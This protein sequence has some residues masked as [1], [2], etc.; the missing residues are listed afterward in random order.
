MERNMD[1]VRTILRVAAQGRLTGNGRGLSNAIPAYSLAE[2]HYHVQIMQEAGLVFQK[3]RSLEM[4]AL[5]LTG[6]G[7]EFLRLASNEGIWRKAKALAMERTG[8]MALVIL[9]CELRVLSQMEAL[10]AGE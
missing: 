1:L 6:E 5:E 3:S 10:A 7:Q 4:C 2:L 8:A 9:K